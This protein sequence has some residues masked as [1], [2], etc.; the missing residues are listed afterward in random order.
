MLMAK[1]DK[2]MRS[3]RFKLICLA[4]ALA[5]LYVLLDNAC[6]FQTTCTWVDQ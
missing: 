3:R 2:F 6:V 5:W 4:V 1:L